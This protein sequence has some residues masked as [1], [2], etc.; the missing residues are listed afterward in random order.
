MTDYEAKRLLDEMQDV[1]GEETSEHWDDVER[2]IISYAKGCCN[3]KYFSWQDLDELISQAIM[4]LFKLHKK[5]EK[6]NKKVNQYYIIKTMKNSFINTFRKRERRRKMR[7]EDKYLRETYGEDGYLD[8]LAEESSQ[9]VLHTVEDELVYS[10][11][12]STIEDKLSDQSKDVLKFILKNQ[13]ITVEAYA[14]ERGLRYHTAL[15]RI[16]RFQ[17]QAKEQMYVWG[18]EHKDEAELM[19]EVFKYISA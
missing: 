10:P 19:A 14:R 13:D 15:K 11:L 12:I 4:A 1:F 6:E 16:E 3:S 7:K 18:K 9:V 2:C 17:R 5:I 8:M